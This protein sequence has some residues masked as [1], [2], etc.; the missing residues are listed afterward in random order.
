MGR[1]VMNRV[2]PYFFD[3]T[4]VRTVTGADGEPCFVAKDVAEALDYTWKGVAGTI[5][6]IPEEW[7]GV[8]SVQT[9]SGQQNMAM[10]SEQ[11]LY[12]FLG[13]SDKPKTLPFQKWLA[14]EVLPS[15][16][17]TGAY[18]PEGLT[19]DAL[20]HSLASQ[21][22]GIIKAVVRKQI[23]DMLQAELP[24]LL[25]GE[26]SR[27]S[28][29]VRYGRTAGQIM[30][31]HRIPPQKNLANRVSRHLCRQKCQSGTV[32]VGASR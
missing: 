6:H 29:G 25:H 9:P 8:C 18:V 1:E 14:G 22:G 20:P 4:E 17:K 16:R 23:E 26:L 10:L 27:Q 2:V 15:I 30:R 13:R 5:S 28:V 7:R 11:G 3:K 21:V 19:L 32:E 31:D 24:R 12:F